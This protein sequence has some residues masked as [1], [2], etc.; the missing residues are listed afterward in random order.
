M[1][2]FFT[3]KNISIVGGIMILI[4]GNSPATILPFIVGTLED[5]FSLSRSQV[6]L[7]VSSELLSIA[8]SSIL[9]GSLITKLNLKLTS[10][11]GLLL[12]IG[13]YLFSST[14]EDHSILQLT[15]IISGIGSGLLIA[16][17]HNILS[18]SK[19]P[20]FS[21]AAFTLA[22]SL[23]G[24]TF[25][26]IAGITSE[27]GGYQY[28]FSTFGYIFL[29]FTTALILI[30]TS[31]L[32]PITRPLSDESSKT[33]VVVLLILGV[34]FFSLPSGGM[35]AFNERLGIEIGLAQS[36]IGIVLFYSL[37]AGL[38]APVLVWSIGSSYGRK[39]PL[40]ICLSSILSCFFL[41]LLTMDKFYYWIGNILWNFTVTVAVIYVL[42]AAAHLSKDGKLASWIN[43]VSLLS[44]ASAP[45]L[46]GFILTNL[47]FIYLLPFLAISLSI[48]ILCILF[49]KNRLD[50]AI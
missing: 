32:K 27:E 11:L 23:C 40:L 21:Y 10:F 5:G 49:T 46:F 25:V 15:R 3:R 19:N 33:P 50:E 28:L 31:I 12:I 17:G 2:A 45:L 44:Q 8:F 30:N 9:F 41:I 35:W 4:A 16:T 6:G 18:S 34:I 7:I 24:A 13:S 47:S 48:S 37:I 1:K 39:K 20:D 43:A 38:L 14:I 36:E 26:R 22:A 29:F 42:A